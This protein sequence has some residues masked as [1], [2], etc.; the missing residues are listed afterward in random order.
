MT[1]RKPPGIAWESWV[2]QQIREARERGEFDDLPGHGKPLPDLDRPRD[3]LWW[4]RKKLQREKVSYSP[5][6]I[7]LRREVDD[8]LEQIATASTETEVR[9]VVASINDRI[10][11][12]NS[13]TISG[14]PTS[15]GVLDVEDVVR[16]WR[17]EQRSAP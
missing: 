8:A 13:H 4:V 9:T 2:E 12:V 17:Q 10:R 7:S 14:P 16:K 3:E 11:Y 6:A 15:I 5:P 1:S